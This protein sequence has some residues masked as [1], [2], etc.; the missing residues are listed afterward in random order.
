MRVD[1]CKMTMVDWR[2]DIAI[3]NGMHQRILRDELVSFDVGSIA[4]EYIVCH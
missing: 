2:R 3:T 1:V 4:H